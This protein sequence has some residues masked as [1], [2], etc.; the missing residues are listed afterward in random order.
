MIRRER[1]QAL[2]IRFGLAKVILCEIGFDE[3][4]QVGDFLA[5]VRSSRDLRRANGL[6]LAT[7]RHK[8]C[9]QHN[10]NGHC[11]DT[12]TRDERCASRRTRRLLRARASS[13]CN[14]SDT[15]QSGE[16]SGR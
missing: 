12:R 7:A 1:L 10:G 3:G 6:C 13:G 14:F 9:T 16:G 8:T 15:F 5:V 11:S 4:H 2:D